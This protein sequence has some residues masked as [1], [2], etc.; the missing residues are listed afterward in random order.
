MAKS[1]SKKED[2]RIKIIFAAIAVVLATGIATAILIP[3]VIKPSLRYKEATELIEKDKYDDAAVI[4][5]E[6][7]DFKDSAEQ[8]AAI[9]EAKYVYALELMD[10]GEYARAITA[11]EDACE[12]YIDTENVKNIKYKFAIGLVEVREYDKAAKIFDKLGD[13]KDSDARLE[14]ACEKRLSAAMV[15]SEVV[16]GSYE[17]DGNTENGAESVEWI[18][19]EKTE[20]SILLIS[21]YAL[22]S[23]RYADSAENFIWERSGIRK[24]LNGDFYNSV[25]NSWEKDMIM[26]SEVTGEVDT[27][28]GKSADFV[29]QDKLYL[30]NSLELSKYFVFDIA[31]ITDC[32]EYAR[33]DSIEECGWWLREGYGAYVTAVGGVMHASNNV[34]LN[35][36]Y[37]VRPV[38]RISFTSD[39]ADAN[40]LF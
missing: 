25:F 13:Y 8:L 6:L 9:P 17:Q 16:L 23:M 2:K 22:A 37:Y 26:S 34:F 24:W 12:N 29:V 1:K 5:A 15:G 20:D 36:S 39:T 21:K 11:F 40:F 7:G 28:F 19:L 3:T 10:D 30:F 4:F 33:N 31:K 32:T 14:N 27:N 38:M 35:E 18:I